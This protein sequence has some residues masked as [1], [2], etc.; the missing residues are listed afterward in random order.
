MNPIYIILIVGIASLIGGIIK[1]GNIRRPV[2]E[3]VVYTIMY[4]PELEKY[5]IREG[6]LFPTISDGGYEMLDKPSFMFSEREAALQY[7]K[8]Y[9]EFKGEK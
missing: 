5:A 8:V 9:K 1:F 6:E 3:E 7:L 4:F 2:K